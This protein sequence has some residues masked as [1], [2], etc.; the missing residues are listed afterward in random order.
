M[1]KLNG[2]WAPRFEKAT[3]ACVLVP[4]A[5]GA[6]RRDAIA[7]R[8]AP[9]S[10][11]RLRRQFCSHCESWDVSALSGDRVEMYCM[12]NRAS[13]FDQDIGLWDEKVGPGFHG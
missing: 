12:F 9:R 11:S 1:V 3:D 7:L 2:E 10:Y 13:S 4:G 5:E 8:H 6:P